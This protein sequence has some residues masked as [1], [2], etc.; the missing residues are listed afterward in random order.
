[1]PADPTS[2]PAPAQEQAQAVLVLRLAGP[3]Q[4]WGERSAFNRRDTPP[5]PT[6]SGVVG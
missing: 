4:S 6:K 2:E 5:Q 3:L 1:M